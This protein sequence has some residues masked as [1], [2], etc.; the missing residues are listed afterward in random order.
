MITSAK[1][2]DE[3]GNAPQP[4]KYHELKILNLNNGMLYQTIG[5]GSNPN[6]TISRFKKSI[7]RL[8]L[9]HTV[10]I[11]LTAMSQT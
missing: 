6:I 7:Q 10:P 3:I 5:F 2:D 4:K 11:P 9:R 1:G 8:G